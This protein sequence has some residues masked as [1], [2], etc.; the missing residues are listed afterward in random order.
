[1]FGIFAIAACWVAPAFF[2]RFCYESFQEFSAPAFLTASYAK[3]L[4]RYWE[5]RSRTKHELIEAGR[6][7]ARQAGTLQIEAQERALLREENRRLE[8]LC[9]LPS[10][11]EL[12]TVV[13][14]VAQRNIGLWWQQ[15]VIRRGRVD[16]IR[17]GA[18]VIDADG[19]VG[20]V[21]EVFAY[22]SV[23]ELIS[24]PSF[25]ISAYVEGSDYPVTFCGSG[26]GPF[27]R[28]YGKIQDIPSDFPARFERNPSILTTGVGGVFPGGLPLGTMSEGMRLTDDGL[29]FEA[30]VDLRPGL[31]SLEEVAVLVP[32]K[33]DVTEYN[34][35]EAA[36]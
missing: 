1:M 35:W 3:D 32:V 7:A 23:V 9:G 14:R 28:P 2:K 36:L 21:R 18:P 5:L 19:V 11:P 30:R 27:L 12:R 34:E 29:F 16:G 22:T 4:A 20:R 26:S 31:A 15:I 6:D 8:K 33:A 17:V 25:R 10:R 24:S 13:A